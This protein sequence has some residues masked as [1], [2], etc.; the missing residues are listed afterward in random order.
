MTVST[1]NLAHKRKFKMIRNQLTSCTS[2]RT[3]MIKTKQN[4][5][6]ER[7]TEEYGIINHGLTLIT[8]VSCKSFKRGMGIMIL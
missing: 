7:W 4:F 6:K 5:I 8:L 3:D 1:A 2:S